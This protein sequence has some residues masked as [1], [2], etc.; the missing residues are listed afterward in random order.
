MGRRRIPRIKCGCTNEGTV[1]ACWHGCGD[2]VMV[3]L[4]SMVLPVHDTAP[5]SGP[6]FCISS[7]T[8]SS[9]WRCRS[10]LPT[11]GTTAACSS[12]DCCAP[13]AVRRAA[14]TGQNQARGDMR[15]RQPAIR[16]AGRRLPV[17]GVPAGQPPLG[18]ASGRAAGRAAWLQRQRFG[19]GHS[20]QRLGSSTRLRRALSLREIIS[21][22]H[23]GAGF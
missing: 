15:R 6:P 18:V 1:R 2:R 13:P 12:P 5:L 7:P 16:L 8:A 21:T 9:A 11:R 23:E 20:R 17:W 4:T 22:G 19:D 14:C 3:P 10:G